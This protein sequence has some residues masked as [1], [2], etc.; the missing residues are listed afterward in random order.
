MSSNQYLAVCHGQSFTTV[1]TLHSKLP[2]TRSTRTLRRETTRFANTPRRRVAKSGERKGCRTSSERAT[3]A[4]T[5]STD[6]WEL[7]AP[8]RGPHAKTRHVA[9]DQRPASNVLGL[10]G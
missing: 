5:H 1:T 2:S 10:S 8:S 3:T 9:P 6:E 7:V 4:K